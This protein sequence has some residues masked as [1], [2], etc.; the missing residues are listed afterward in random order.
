MR[1]GYCSASKVQT[2]LVFRR[3]DGVLAEAGL[4]NRPVRYGVFDGL[5]RNGGCLRGTPGRHARGKD[6]SPNSRPRF[7]ALV[8][9]RINAG[10]LGFLFVSAGLLH[11]L[12]SAKV[13]IDACA[14]RIMGVLRRD[15]Q[16]YVR[17]CFTVDSGTCWRALK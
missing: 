7:R 16:R 14:G 12:S 3:G 17:V 1:T 13:S 5:L 2:G 6:C 9:P 15:W 11:C 10:V 4:V 8:M